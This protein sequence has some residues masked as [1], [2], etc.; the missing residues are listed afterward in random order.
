[1]QVNCSTKEIEVFELQIK[2][3]EEKS[4]L[5]KQEHEKLLVEFERLNKER[6]ELGMKELTLSSSEE[7]TLP[8]NSWRSYKITP[9]TLD[10]LRENIDEEKK[11]I[12]E[13]EREEKL[14][15]ELNNVIEMREKNGLSCVSIRDWGGFWL[16]GMGYSLTEEKLKTLKEDTKKELEMKKIREQ[17]EKER[18]QEEKKKTNISQKPNT[19]KKKESEKFNNP[20]ADFFGG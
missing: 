3:R 20:F 11:K 13:K 8:G 18:E 10:M 12:K 7:F 15:L 1:M 14:L 5:L 19:S 4:K 6:I 2:K 17:K 16:R 9:K